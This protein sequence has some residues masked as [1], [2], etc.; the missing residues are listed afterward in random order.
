M[1]LS[2]KA[3]QM[4]E[5]AITNPG[6][7]K[8]ISDAIDNALGGNP[9]SAITFAGN[10]TFSGN[11]VHS[12]S[13]VFSGVNDFK[14]LKV[15]QGTALVAGDFA[16]HANWGSTASVA[17]A[18]GGKD[19]KFQITVTSAGTGQGANPTVVLTFKDGT[20]TVAPVAVVCR[21][22]GSQ[23]TLPVFCTCTATTLTITFVGTPVAAETFIING[24][25]LG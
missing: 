25:V 11:N 21:G 19:N 10:D 3:R 23:N 20:F 18:T 4:L 22:G 17:V 2:I 16:L 7:A 13:N 6:V 14:R 1:S 9:A 15:N 5:I 24:H 8:E 12:G